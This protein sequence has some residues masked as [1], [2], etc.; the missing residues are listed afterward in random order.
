MLLL[1]REAKSVGVESEIFH[2]SSSSE[3]RLYSCS[4]CFMAS[5][6]V[7]VVVVYINQHF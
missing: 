3:N 1:S 5:F 6:F 4:S 7:I 2:F